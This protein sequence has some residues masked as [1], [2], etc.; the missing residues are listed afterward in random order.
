MTFSDGSFGLGLVAQK[1]HTGDGL[2]FV[3]AL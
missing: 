3:S 2:F 1:D